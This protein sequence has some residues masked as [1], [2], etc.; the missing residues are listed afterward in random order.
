MLSPARN[1]FRVTRSGSFSSSGGAG[2]VRLRPRMA[3]VAEG[4]EN[5]G[6]D[7]ANLE[8][9]CEDCGEECS[10]TGTLTPYSLSN[11]SG[12]HTP[13]SR[14]MLSSDRQMQLGR[15]SLLVHS[16]DTHIAAKAKLTDL[17]QADEVMSI[18]PWCGQCSRMRPYAVLPL[19]PEEVDPVNVA[20]LK[21]LEIS[22]RVERRSRSKGRRMCYSSETSDDS[23]EVAPFGLGVADDMEI[24]LPKRT[25]RTRAIDT[26]KRID[27]FSERMKVPITKG[28]FLHKDVESLDDVQLKDKP[29]RS[30]FSRQ[31]YGGT[32]PVLQR[33]TADQVGELERW[34]LN[35]VKSQYIQVAAAFHSL[36]PREEK[37]HRHAM[38][39]ATIRA[40]LKK[41]NKGEGRIKEE[42]KMYLFSKLRM[43]PLLC[44]FP[45]ELL[46]S[47]ARQIEVCSFS[48]RVE[49]FSELAPAEDI[50]ILV[51]GCVE[52]RSDIIAL[53][54][55]QFKEAP[56]AL[57]PW[58]V[59]VKD[60]SD[61]RFQI[62][63]QSE[64]IRSRTAVAVLS[65]EGVT[66]LVDTFRVPFSVVQAVSDF[67]RGEEI[68]ERNEK[69]EHIFA[70][71]MRME[72]QKCLRNAEIFQLDTF[73]MNFVLLAEGGGGQLR[74]QAR[75]YL[76]LEGEVQLVYPSRKVTKRGRRVLIPN[77][78]KERRQAGSLLGESA[79]YGEPYPHSAVVSSSTVKV[80]SLKV[81][82]YLD[83]FLHR[84]TPLERP[85]AS[86]QLDENAP[87]P[88][89]GDEDSD[90]ARKL[91]EERKR[92]LRCR[93]D[94][95]DVKANQR[96]LR[97][98]ELPRTRP[99][100]NAE[101]EKH[102][103][104]APV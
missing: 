60:S 90:V 83:R 58:D 87:S 36:A 64:R 16:Q 13:S 17:A 70:P 78:P 28:L 53:A 27:V 75:L 3:V 32:A 22:R 23:S 44:D 12:T 8:D 77:K 76:I 19:Y 25:S 38:N 98:P 66:S 26:F 92:A 89:E 42:E 81:Y 41:L 31:L 62:R 72:P 33:L 1:R 2:R 63:P 103:A 35:H 54:Q 21:T 85:V 52:L 39:V 45:D 95:A 69:V 30:R 18:T 46:Y 49:I 29:A 43:V 6:A 80:L 68:R 88:E 91:L 50:Y 7:A 86:T 14:A 57:L 74:K 37:R 82:D 51:S 5:E 71:A 101:L 9:K 48:S 55:E 20:R 15:H 102:R 93:A 24:K 104:A 4:E 99:P 61:G 97:D 67:F 47:C 56:V 100:R 65:E 34:M 11:F 94:L 96:T 40:L 79:V 59:L 84:T 10:G 73:H